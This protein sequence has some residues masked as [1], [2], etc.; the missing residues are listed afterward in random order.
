VIDS[1]RSRLPNAEILRVERITFKGRNQSYNV[2]FR[3]GTG[4]VQTAGV[5]RKG[6]VVVYEQQEKR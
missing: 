2:V 3:Q 6:E 4:Q 1:F 5:N